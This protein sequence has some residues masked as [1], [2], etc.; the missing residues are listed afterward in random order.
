MSAKKIEFKRILREYEF[1]LQDLNDVKDLQSEASREFNR[2]LAEKR[3]SD[4]LDNKQLEGMAEEPDVEPNNVEN[5]PLFKKLFRK[6]VIK[7]HP[8]KL[9]SD[10]NVIEKARIVELYDEA[11]RANDAGNWA[12]LITV[13]IKLEIELEPEYYEHIDKIREETNK[14]KQQIDQIQGSAAWK[15]Y[16]TPEEHRAAILETYIKH[17]EQILLAP[18]KTKIKILGLGHPRTGT[19]YTANLLQGWGLD[20]GHETLG[21]DGIVAW[22]LAVLNGPWPYITEELNLE[23]ELIIYN[24]RDPKTS[25]PSIAFTENTKSQS[26]GFR[27]SKGGV[28]TSPNRVEQAINSIIR[29]DKLIQSRKPNFV[30]RV[31]DQESELFEFLKGRF[32]N[33]KYIETNKKVNSRNHPDWTELEHELSKVRPSL[34]S[35]INDYCLKYGYEPLF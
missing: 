2:A 21:A 30:Y 14:L 23:P 31:E 24:V 5:E 9:E 12:M 33:I 20:V 17:L 7:S 11:V 32:D 6:I 28:L 3:R 25:I 4:L 1:S 26:L 19:G 22:Q 16:H 10:L 8:D 15:W 27:V 35:K 34:R 18:K 13:A 29:W